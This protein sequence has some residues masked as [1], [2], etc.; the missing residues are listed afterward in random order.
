MSYLRLV[1]LVVFLALVTAAYIKG[2]S[3]GT[4]IADG[5]ISQ[6]QVALDAERQ[7]S[8][9][10]EATIEQNRL[11]A[12][13]TAQQLSRQLEDQA[14]A[15]APSSVACLPADRVRRLNLR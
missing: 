11:A 8:A 9:Q 5:K 1:L 14:H 3:D 15:Q 6:A 4:A 10:L 7:K 2:R 13:A 12:E